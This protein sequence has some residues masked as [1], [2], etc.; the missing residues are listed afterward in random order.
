MFFLFRITIKINQFRGLVKNVSSF[1]C[2]HTQLVW[3]F[4]QCK[5]FV[6]SNKRY[7]YCFLHNFSAFL[8]HSTSS[9]LLLMKWHFRNGDK[10]QVGKKKVK[11]FSKNWKP[12]QW[13]CNCF[14]KLKNGP[15]GCWKG[16]GLT[17]IRK[18]H[19]KDMTLPK[20]SRKKYSNKLSMK[21]LVKD[22]LVKKKLC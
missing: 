12:P 17:R 8:K 2:F 9:S 18:P 13:Q 15:K 16:I 14:K 3:V 6:R 20:M 1:E 7:P 4:I 19:I 21:V 22:N 5:K 11:L 10:F